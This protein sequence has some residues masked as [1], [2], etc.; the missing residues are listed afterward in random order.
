M[1]TEREYADVIAENVRLREE[2]KC[3]Y[4]ANVKT[5]HELA[6]SRARI[7]AL[8]QQVEE[9]RADAERY[10]ELRDGD[11]PLA[12]ADY[13]LIPKGEALVGGRL[14]AE[15]DSWV[16]AREAQVADPAA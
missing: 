8:E 6:E 11:C 4:D 2:A 14:D 10:V 15:I 7:A 3:E 13:I 1:S 16:A 12:V 5:S 9:L